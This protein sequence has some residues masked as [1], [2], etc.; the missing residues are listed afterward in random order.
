M[1]STIFVEHSTWPMLAN[2]ST[3]AD[4]LAGCTTDGLFKRVVHVNQGD[5]LHAAQHPAANL[6]EFLCRLAITGCR[7]V[8]FT[9]K[10]CAVAENGDL[11]I[12]VVQDMHELLDLH[13][14]LFDAV[15]EY[16]LEAAWARLPHSWAL[17]EIL[18]RR[19]LS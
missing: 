1:P 14:E 17:N 6:S 7:P 9:F 8:N 12:E 13:P 15:P 19:R 18:T 3:V 16:V 10:I 11:I 5:F 2:P 4:A